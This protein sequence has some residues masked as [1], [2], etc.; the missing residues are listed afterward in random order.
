M[1]LGGQSNRKVNL[2]LS[3]AVGQNE[4][5]ECLLLSI[6]GQNG[7]RFNLSKRIITLPNGDV[8]VLELDLILRMALQYG[9]EVLF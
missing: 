5:G 6:C 7:I 9:Y 1:S 2:W 8:E 4:L 3:S